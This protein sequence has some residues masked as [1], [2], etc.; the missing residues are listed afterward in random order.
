MERVGRD[1]SREKPRKRLRARATLRRCAAV[2]LVGASPPDT[3]VLLSNVGEVKEVG[4]RTC[5]RQRSIH[6]QPRKLG[7]KH[8]EVL[9]P[10]GSRMLRQRPDTFD[11]AEQVVA[12]DRPKR[13]AQQLAQQAHVV[14]Q[15]LVRIVC[16]VSE[17][18]RGKRSGRTS[19]VIDCRSPVA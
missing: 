16:H 6:R 15:R 18:T 1:A 11:G 13:C 4:E 12:L 9:H 10:L 14:A 17:I 8:F 7:R 3:V 5:D 19:A 2:M